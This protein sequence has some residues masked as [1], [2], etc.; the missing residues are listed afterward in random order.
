MNDELLSDI[1]GVDGEYG[2]LDGPTVIT[3][4]PTVWKFVCSDAEV[5]IIR[6]PRREG[7]SVGAVARI[8]RIAQEGIAQGAAGPMRVAAVRDTWKNLSRTVIET[9][10]EGHKHGWWDVQFMA[11]DTEAVM[12]DGLVHFSFFGMDRPADA[13][14]FQGFEAATLW[15]DEPAPAADLSSGVPADVFGIGLSSL[16]QRGFR[17][18]VQLS[19]NP[20][21]RKHWT[22][23]VADYLEEHGKGAMRVEVFDI[24][25][26]ENRYLPAGYRERMRLGLEAAGRF[27]LVRR[28]V[29]GQIGSVQVGE[30]VTPGFS[31]LHIA[32]EPLPLSMRWKTYRGWD[33][34][35]HPAMVMIQ[36]TPSGHVHVVGALYATG[37]GVEEFILQRVLPW[38]Q[39]FG[40][41]PPRPGAPDG[42]G[43][44]PRGG[45]TIEDII[46]PSGFTPDQS[47]SK[48]SAR[49]II[50]QLLR[51]SCHAGPVSID[52]RVQSVNTLLGRMPGG[53]PMLQIDP[54]ECAPLVEGLQGGW[55]RTRSPS[56]I[57]GPIVK[58]DSSNPCD[59]F[60]YVLAWLFPP[61][62]VVARA[63]ALANS[64]TVLPPP[65]TF[66]GV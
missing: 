58:N 42:F 5:V 35:H 55:H 54:Q 56:G 48:R 2:H 30:A 63:D 23:H 24:P 19:M 40:I 22:L 66:W 15:I 10:K 59:A 20:P 26:G 39:H 1:I 36:I 51:T 25:K 21:D 57:I 53:K 33:L 28:L 37:F 64:R 60:G 49:K 52:A 18:S 38:Q 46:D 32:K 16:S 7:K 11:S 43:R 47:S 17:A 8:I 50:E 14:K 34:W 3:L 65:G 29:E 62:E 27:D 41:L 12:N 44:G 4:S 13:N 31:D 45:F 61:G 9:L 6:G